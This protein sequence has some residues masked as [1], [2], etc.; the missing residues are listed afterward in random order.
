MIRELDKRTFRRLGFTW[1]QIDA[2][3][4]AKD[5]E[6]KLQPFIDINSNFWLDAQRKHYKRTVKRIEEYRNAHPD[7]RLTR[8][9]L[10]E[11]VDQWY[12]KRYRDIWKWLKKLYRQFIKKLK[13]K[14]VTANTKAQNKKGKRG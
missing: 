2:I 12:D 6:G 9:R 14:N 4:N 11:L 13:G 5:P 7:K 10:D 3:D 1:K 8:A